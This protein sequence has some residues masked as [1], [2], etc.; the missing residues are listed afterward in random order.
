MDSGGVRGLPSLAPF[1]LAGLLRD[2]PAFRPARAV[3]VGNRSDVEG[4]LS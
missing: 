4:V 2:V 1:Y 3:V